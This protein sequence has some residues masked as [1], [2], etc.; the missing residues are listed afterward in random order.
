MK[1]IKKLVLRR[2]CWLFASFPAHVYVQTTIN[3][4]SHGTLKDVAGTET[5]TDLI[6]TS[7]I[8]A[9]DMTFIRDNFHSISEILLYNVNQEIS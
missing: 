7:S 1:A 2:V 4:S 8:D 5:V 3:F 9:C 6:I